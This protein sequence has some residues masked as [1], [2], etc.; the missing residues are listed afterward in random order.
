MKFW[1]GLVISLTS[2]LLGI[3][4]AY[5]HVFFLGASLFAPA[6]MAITVIPYIASTIIPSWKTSITEPDIVMRG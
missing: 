4:L 5:L 3:I 2:F 6:L 1:E